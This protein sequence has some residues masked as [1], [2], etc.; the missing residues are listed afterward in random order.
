MD[1]VAEASAAEVSAAEATV[2]GEV[3]VE[4]EVTEA[5]DTGDTGAGVSWVAGAMEVMGDSGVG[6]SEAAVS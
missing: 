3:T 1:S 4:E 5:V 2:A 6:A